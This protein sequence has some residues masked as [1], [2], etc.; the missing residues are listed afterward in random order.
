LLHPVT[1]TITQPIAMAATSSKSTPI[2]GL[3][4]P[5]A[6]NTW[7]S[8][9]TIPLIAGLVGGQTLATALQTIG[10]FSEEIFRGDRLPILDFTALEDIQAPTE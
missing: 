4:L 3:D 7:V 6:A 8:L 9:A 10:G 5:L 1:L 2:T